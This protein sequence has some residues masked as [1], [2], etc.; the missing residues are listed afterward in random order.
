MHHRERLADLGTA[1]RKVDRDRG[2]DTLRDGCFG[3]GHHV[4]VG[5][6]VVH[7]QGVVPGVRVCVARGDEKYVGGSHIHRQF[8]RV[9]LLRLAVVEVRAHEEVTIVAPCVAGRS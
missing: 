6:A 5:V 4:P 8:A 9:N 3:G 1:A 7:V 2:L